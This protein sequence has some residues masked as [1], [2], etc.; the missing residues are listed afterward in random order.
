MEVVII[1]GLSGAG[2]SKA[3]DWF[4]DKGYYC[5]DNMPPALIK[6]IIDLT[7]SGS[8]DIERAAFVVD[9]RG[10]K[11]FDELKDVIETLRN[12][13]R[14]DFKILFIEASNQS[15]V[16]RYKE[17]RRQHPLSENII[18]AKTI[19]EER[20]KLKSLKDNADYVVDTTTLKVADFHNEL[21]N[22]FFK[23]TKKDSF[24]LKFMSFGYKYRVPSEADWVIDVRFIPNPYYVPSLKHLT[25]NNK[26][27][28]QYVLK[29][30][31]TK[32]F[33]EGLK[34]GI[35]R[36]V[37]YYSKEGKYSLTIAFGCTGGQHRSVTLAN[38]FYRIF[39]EEGW[40]V[41][42]EHKEL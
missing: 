13:E 38:E 36:L 35:L 18:T 31:V 26:K 32:N 19:Q 9:I 15:L 39:S 2:K 17:A 5:I 16:R 27:I 20:D 29:H 11:F 23:K 33:I 3:A 10:G 42:L 14:L 7:C 41:T 28:Q 24:T 1:T 37:P 4:E 34:D 8:R 25:G 40:R 6:N 21:D 30:D 12:D 22:L